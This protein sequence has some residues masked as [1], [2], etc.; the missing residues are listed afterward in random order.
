V[1]HDTR[2]IRLLHDVDV[3]HALHDL[4]LLLLLACAGQRAVAR[5]WLHAYEGTPRTTRRYLCKLLLE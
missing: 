1:D 4:L 3:V 2:R 5:P